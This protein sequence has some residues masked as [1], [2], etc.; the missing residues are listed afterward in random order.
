V[1]IPFHQHGQ[2]NGGMQLVAAREDDA[3][4]LAIASALGAAR[5]SAR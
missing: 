2:P 1:T 4:L 3:R 5:K